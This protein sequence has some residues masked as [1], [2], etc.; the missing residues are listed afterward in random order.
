MGQRHDIL[1]VHGSWHGGWAFD[2]IGAALREAGH[3]VL[4]PCLLGLGRDAANL[5]RDIG[6]W[7]HVDQLERIVREQDLHNLILVGHSYSGALVHGL[8]GRVAD[9]LRAVVHLEGAIP[10]PGCSIMQM[11]PEERRR[12]TL[13]MAEKQGDGWRVS[14]PDPRTWGALSNKQIAWL[15]SK[16]TD[17]AIKTYQD[18][19]LVDLE[20]ANC[21]HYYLYANDRDP[22]PYQAVIDR[23]SQ[24]PDWQIAATL[25]GHELMFT[26][27]EAVLRVIS[28]AV[29]GGCLPSNL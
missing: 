8:E 6:L 12:S 3:R 28:T 23:F 9:R 26:N 17:Q 14:P 11:W 24:A 22:Q 27:P 1:L 5:H 16:L 2:D 10:A 15:S 4:A 29:A 18:I 21:P 20:S 13:D 25:G 19:M 7:T